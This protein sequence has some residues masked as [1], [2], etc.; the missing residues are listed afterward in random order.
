M[1]TVNIFP[2]FQLKALAAPDPNNKLIITLDTKKIIAS[3][4]V[5]SMTEIDDAFVTKRQIYP[6]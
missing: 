3:Q 2:I 5:S 4:L 1:N 6:K